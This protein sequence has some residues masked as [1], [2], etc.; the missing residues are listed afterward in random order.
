MDVHSASTEEAQK[1]ACGKSS[2]FAPRDLTDGPPHAEAVEA[3]LHTA[4]NGA[5]VVSSPEGYI[6]SGSGKYG[7]P[8]ASTVEETYHVTKRRSAPALIEARTSPARSAL[9]DATLLDSSL[10]VSPLTP[11]TH[12]RL[13]DTDDDRLIN[14]SSSPQQD[15]SSSVW[16]TLC[17]VEKEKTQYH[18]MVEQLQADLAAERE[19]AQHDR[20][21]ANQA[22]GD[23]R[24]DIADLEA[25]IS[26]LEDQLETEKQTSQHHLDDYQRCDRDATM[27]ITGCHERISEL[28]VD[29]AYEK[30]KARHNYSK[31]EEFMGLANSWRDAFHRLGHDPEALWKMLVEELRVR[32]V[33]F[34]YSGHLHRVGLRKAVLGA[35]DADEWVDGLDDRS[36][37]THSVNEGD[38]RGSAMD[39]M[40]KTGDIVIEEHIG[41]NTLGETEQGQS[42]VS[43]KE[44][45]GGE[46]H[47][48][49][50][51]NKEHVAE[52]DDH[53]ALNDAVDANRINEQTRK[54][55]GLQSCGREPVIYVNAGEAILHDQRHGVSQ[56]SHTAD[57][58]IGDQEEIS[59]LEV[60]DEANI[61]NI[62]SNHDLA[63]VSNN[64]GST[65]WVSAMDEPGSTEADRHETT[66]PMQSLDDC[67]VG[68][69]N[70]S[71]E[72]KTAAWKLPSPLPNPQ[73]SSFG[74][75]HAL[76]SPTM[77]NGLLK[78][79]L[80]S[81]HR[82]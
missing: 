28:E 66:P 68:A 19:N 57:L 81:H 30:R 22:L 13:A 73:T 3:S 54:Y 31:A 42:H 50:K 6:P 79:L 63:N 55:T 44:K 56:G 18:E 32:G 59:P 16:G 9:S 2:A 17:K 53:F 7:Q 43:A 69:V 82:E 46:T 49:P 33:V 12:F 21:I 8:I 78:S 34:D 74:L 35:D 72:P 67:K 64:D 75:R 36:L 24:D 80:W 15:L 27:V 48:E 52:K 71:G 10:Q 45:T 4:S 77:G 70:R 61:Q 38:D 76:V 5:D 51:A 62:D 20:G 25:E 65:D 11:R 29:L 47:T 1:V 23:I 40:P 39:A 26:D 37:L 14:M 58:V 41:G 60:E